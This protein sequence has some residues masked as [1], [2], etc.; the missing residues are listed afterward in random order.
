MFPSRLG[1]LLW[2]ATGCIQKQTKRSIPLINVLPAT[3]RRFDYVNSLKISISASHQI[4]WLE[5]S[6][7]SEAISLIISPVR[8]PIV[9]I[10]NDT[11]LIHTQ[12]LFNYISGCRVVLKMLY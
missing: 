10:D 7:S 12:L 6:V 5:L 9:R 2:E 3:S 4:S 11:T 8:H 1:S